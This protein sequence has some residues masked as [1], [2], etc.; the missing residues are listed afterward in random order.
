MG[1]LFGQIGDGSEALLQ[2]SRE[3]SSRGM[4]A[5]EMRAGLFIG[6]GFL[7]AAA[8]C[9]AA[10]LPSAR[11]LEAGA[12][13]LMIVAYAFLSR[14]EFE[15]GTGSAVPTQLVLVPMLFAVPVGLVP[16]LVAVGWMLGGLPDVLR[17]RTPASRL[18][19]ALPSS[20]HAIGPVVVLGVAGEPS[21]GVADWWLYGLALAAQFALDIG[22]TTSWEWV[23]NRVSPRVLLRPL[24]A[25]HVVDLA[26]AP[27]G[28][29]AAIADTIVANSFLLVMPLAFLAAGY[30]RERHERLDQ[31][32]ALNSA[33]RGTAMLLGEVVESDDAYTGAHSRD[34]VELAVGVARELGLTPREQQQAELAALLHDVGKIA[35]PNEI[36]NKPAALTPDERALVEKHTIEGEAMLARV[37]GA[38]GEIGTLVRSCHERWDGNG[39]PDGLAQEA[40]PLVSRIVSCCDA[41]SAITTDRP[42]RAARSRRE[43]LLELRRCSGSQFDPRVVEA[44]GSVLARQAHVGSEPDGN[45]TRAA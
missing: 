39:Y 22:A 29:L 6:G 43:A 17:G 12:V 34:V 40:I 9:A 19:L 21:P 44:L 7:L 18:L 25:A 32:L 23:A 37:G 26:L 16:V 20:W 11:P 24:G 41:Y 36:I 15:V 13:V 2:E 30:A 42:Y 27:I 5:G 31:A 4:T 33:Y 1:D 28:L 14:I 10:L 38:L 3:R 8:A 35:I 45:M